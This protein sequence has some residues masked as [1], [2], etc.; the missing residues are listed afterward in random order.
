MY[1]CLCVFCSFYPPKKG[2]QKGPKK[3]PK[4][5]KSPCT[6]NVVPES[7]AALRFFAKR[8]KGL[9]GR[10]FPELHINQALLRDTPKSGFLGGAPKMALFRRFYYFLPYSYNL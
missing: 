1:T 5:A 2:G 4:T 7:T 8:K 6:K 10:K 9:F 3:G